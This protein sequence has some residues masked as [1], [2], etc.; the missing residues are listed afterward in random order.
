MHQKTNGSPVDYPFF[1]YPPPLP[2]SKGEY[3]QVLAESKIEPHPACMP[4][5][6]ILILILILTLTL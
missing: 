5:G 4:T 2:P 1:P 3:H 6:M